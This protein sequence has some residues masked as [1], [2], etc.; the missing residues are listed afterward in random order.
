MKTVLR[1]LLITATLFFTLSGFLSAGNKSFCNVSKKQNITI[2]DSVLN[3]VLR[4][5]HVTER[6]LLAETFPRNLEN[7]VD[8]LAEGSGQQ[9]GQEVSFLWPYSGVISG[10]VALYRET[11]DG[12]YLDLLENHLL[13]GLEKYW[14]FGRNPAAYQSYPTFAGI[15]LSL[16]HI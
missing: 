6:G 9:H 16:I 1:V 13:P 2:S 7:K 4:L 8:Y 10:V 15:S 14:D 12:K 11:R 3:R 5:Y